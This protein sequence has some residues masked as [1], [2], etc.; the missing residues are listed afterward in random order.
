MKA[1]LS[2]QIRGPQGKDA[3]DLDMVTNCTRAEAVGK[4]IKELMPKLDLHIPAEHEAFVNLAYQ[5][6]YLSEKQILDIDCQIISDCNLLFVFIQND[7]IGGGT[8]IEIKFA[9]EHHIP[10][11]FIYGGT[12]PAIEKVINIV[13]HDFE[14]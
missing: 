4:F 14:K 11:Y 3:T 6:K 5:N 13:K 2:H 8:G 9:Q 7:W 10:I 12:I 1:Y